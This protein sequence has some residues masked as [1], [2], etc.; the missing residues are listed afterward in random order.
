MLE[1]GQAFVLCSTETAVK[2]QHGL[3]LPVSTK[4][5]WSACKTRHRF[6]CFSPSVG[7]RHTTSRQRIAYID[8]YHAYIL[9]QQT[10]RVGDGEHTVTAPNTKGQVRACKQRAHQRTTRRHASQP[11]VPLADTTQVPAE[12]RPV[13]STASSPS[14]DWPSRVRGPAEI[15]FRHR[16]C[17]YRSRRWG[18]ASCKRAWQ[19]AS[20]TPN[21]RKGRVASI[22]LGTRTPRHRREES[23]KKPIFSGAL[24]A[25]QA[26][27]CP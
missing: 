15:V 13:T 3:S 20:V 21:T 16:S 17:A 24:S 26:L 22:L 11:D 2:R 27:W 1:V 7:C 12:S 25:F 23:L 4:S 19:V 10:P 9:Q 14:A 18:G 8:R 6:S 5:T